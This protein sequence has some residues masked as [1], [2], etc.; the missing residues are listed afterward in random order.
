MEMTRMESAPQAITSQI[1]IPPT[2]IIN[3]VLYPESKY[4]ERMK[5]GRD[6]QFDSADGSDAS[7][8]AID[9][10]DPRLTFTYHEFPLRSMDELMD[11]AIQE[12][13]AKKGFKPR[14]FVDLGSGCGRCVLYAALAG[15]GGNENHQTWD[16]VHGIEISSLMHDYAVDTVVQKGVDEGH[17]QRYIAISEDDDDAADLPISTKI[18]FHCGAATDLKRVLSQADII[19]CYS[20]VFDDEGFNAD[21]GAMILSKEW[22]LMLADVCR[23]GT[24]VVT[25]DRALNPAFGWKLKHTLEVDNPSLLQSTGYVSIKE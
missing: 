7:I 17:L 20:T 10:N 18:Y 2:D 16:E 8:L 11:L 23:E 3:N 13:E 5:I 14:I 15:S 24:A 21:I 1:E 12:F 6:A 22:S 9:A 19:F 4:N 25:T